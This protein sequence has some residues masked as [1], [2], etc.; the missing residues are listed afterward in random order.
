MTCVAGLAVSCDGCEPPPPPGLDA[1]V[2][3]PTS[4]AINEVM[5]RNEST[6]A[7]ANGEFDD[8]V[9][10]FN[11]TD[12]EIVLDGFT[13]ADSGSAP[14]GFPAGA[15]VPPNGFLVLFAD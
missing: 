15:V 3:V 8:W 7:D 9:E 12:Q 10:L 11:L 4:L 14:A 6:H 2:G 1:G 5:S 13:L